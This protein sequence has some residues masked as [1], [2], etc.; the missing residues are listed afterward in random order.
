MA[1]AVCPNVSVCM[2]ANCIPQGGGLPRQW[3]QDSAWVRVKLVPCSG[4]IDVQYILHIFEDGADAVCVVACPEGDCTLAQGNYRARVRTEM[5]KKLLQEIGMDANSM[6]LL[7]C[8]PSESPE[9]FQQKVREVV[10][11]LV[12]NCRKDAE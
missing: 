5:V 1:K 6:E 11:G 7:H 4:K 2:C 9:E 12:S 8:S 10:A 3:Q